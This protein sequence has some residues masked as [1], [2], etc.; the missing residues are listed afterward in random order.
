MQ[1]SITKSLPVIAFICSLFSMVILALEGSDGATSITNGLL[2]GTTIFIQLLA[3]CFIFANN[4]TIIRVGYAMIGLVGIEYLTLFLDD[5][6]I[7]GISSIL[8]I[9]I[10]VLYLITAIIYLINATLK[11][12]GFEKNVIQKII[13]PEPKDKYSVLTD[14]KKLLD[15]KAISDDEYNYV[16]SNV[17][18]GK[19]VK[20]SA[21]EISEFKKLVDQ[22]IV[23]N[24]DFE[25]LKKKMFVE[26]NKE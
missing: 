20:I 22:E 7:E 8:T 21:E 23:S 12:F 19:K 13:H 26:E 11:Y 9:V 1:R 4:K 6:D 15:E 14:W 17:L 10:M 24:E 18:E 2:T 16:K 3:I 25:A 5:P